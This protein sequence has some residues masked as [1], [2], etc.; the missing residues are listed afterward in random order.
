MQQLQAHKNPNPG[1]P[2]P[3]S[4]QQRQLRAITPQT[5]D[6]AEAQ[7]AAG[8]AMD[9]AAAKGVSLETVTKTLEKAYGGNFTALAKIVPRTPR[10]D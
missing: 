8:L 6:I 1:R 3:T 4:A 5:R 9:V 10:H 2:I 7:K